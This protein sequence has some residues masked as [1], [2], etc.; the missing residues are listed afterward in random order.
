M[1]IRVA[2]RINS[3][4]VIDIMADVMLA[5]GVPEHPVGQRR[6]EWPKRA[7]GSE[8]RRSIFAPGSPWGND[9]ATASHSTANCARVKPTPDAGRLRRVMGV[10]DYSM[11]DRREAPQ[12]HAYGK[13]RVSTLGSDESVLQRRTLAAIFFEPVSTTISGRSE[14]LVWCSMLA[15]S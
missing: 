6:G 5:K 4:V 7:Q 15:L 9:A 11:F 12:Y 3:F 13:D 2:R 8:Q 14:K 10:R 1:A